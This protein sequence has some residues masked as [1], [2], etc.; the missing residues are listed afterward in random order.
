LAQ[1]ADVPAYVVASNR[2]LMGIAAARPT[3]EEALLEVHGMGRQ[4]VARYGGPFVEAVRGWTG[5]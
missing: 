2:T 3:S 5:C 1:A 4:R